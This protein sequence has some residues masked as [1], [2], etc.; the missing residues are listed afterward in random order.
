[1]IR[2]RF[3]VAAAL[4]ALIWSAAA[5]AQTSATQSTF[6]TGS[7]AH[8]FQIRCQK[9]GQLTM[10]IYQRNN[11]SEYQV[12]RNISYIQLGNGKY[13]LDFMRGFTSP[14]AH[15]VYFPAIDES[16]EITQQ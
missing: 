12:A 14:T 2:V 3:T 11:T 13:G 6:V 8:D 15:E 16:C 7:D 1:M 9:N 4:V 10:G 5:T